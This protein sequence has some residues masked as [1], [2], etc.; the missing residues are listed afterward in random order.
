M[1]ENIQKILSVY[2]TEIIGGLLG[3]LI[4]LLSKSALSFIKNFRVS[5]QHSGII[6][7]YQVYSP[8]RSDVERLIH[9][10]LV[11]KVRLGRLRV[12]M[13]NSAYQFTGSIRITERNI[14]I[15]LEGVQHL[16]E[17]HLVFHSPLSKNI[18]R[19]WGVGACISILGDPFA[20]IF[21]LS[22]EPIEKDDLMRNFDRVYDKQ[23]GGFLS[24]KKE[25]SFSIIK[26][27]SS[28]TASA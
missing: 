25:D 23:V 28:I 20:R 22:K 17:L 12:K 13:Y 19:L 9:Y 14:Y 18:I 7:T 4:L 2:S 10:E 21:L 27:S 11:I 26:A 3:S 1:L 6:G 24:L 5:S 8:D 15:N 16:E